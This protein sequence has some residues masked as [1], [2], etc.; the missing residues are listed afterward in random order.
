MPKNRG[1]RFHPPRIL[2]LF[3]AAMIAELLTFTPPVRAQNPPPDSQSLTAAPAQPTT[4]PPWALERRWTVS[5]QLTY[6]LEN[7]IPR[8]LS[9]VNM[10]IAA[11]QVGWVVWDS[12]HSSLPMNR[13]EIISEG[14]LGSAFHPGGHLAGDT[15]LFRFGFKP[16][17]RVVPFFDAG[18]AALHTALDN[19][20]PEISGHTQFLSQGG[21][22]VQYFH[23]PGRAFV[24]E[25]RYFHM[26]NAGLQQP[27]HGFNGNIISVGYRWFLRRRSP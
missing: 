13:F 10:L 14:V 18:I 23:R 21:I 25:Y 22:G 12:P 4:Q 3:I 16:V 26:S 9:H 27:N 20:A 11:P 5:F 19:N 8:N 15:L 24:L 6:G 2:T 17:R 1:I 7:N